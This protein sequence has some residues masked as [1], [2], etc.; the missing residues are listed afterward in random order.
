MMRLSQAAFTEIKSALSQQMGELQAAEAVVNL[1]APDGLADV[2][3]KRNVKK[4]G[5]KTYKTRSPAKLT[6][7]SSVLRAIQAKPG[8]TS[9]DI[10]TKVLPRIKTASKNPREALHQTLFQLRKNG[11]IIRSKTGKLRLANGAKAT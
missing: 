9:S 8:S 7:T 3:R 5:R 6:M 2:S 11:T 1:L 10:I 4:K